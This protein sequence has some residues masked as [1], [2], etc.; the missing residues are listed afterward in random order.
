MTKRQTINETIPNWLI[1]SGIFNALNDFDVP[2]R[3]SDIANELDME[4]HGNI[5]GDKFISPLVSKMK[6]G[7]TL[8]TAEMKTLAGVIYHMYIDNWRREWD[9]LDML[10]NP[11]ENYNMVEKM[12]NDI[13]TDA[14][15]RTHTRTDNTTHIKTGT[16]TDTKNLTDRNT[17][18]VTE[19]TT[20]NLTKTTT[21]NL[22]ETTTPNVTDTS[23][24]SVYAFNS[25]SP[26]PTGTSSTSQTGTNTVTN[27]G[28]TTDTE[29]GSNTVTR[30]GTDTTTHTGS[31]TLTHNTSD[32][33]TGTVTDADSGT[34]THTRNYHLT[35]SGNIGV[36]TSQQMIQ[37]ERDLY[38]WNIFY[39][40]VFPDIDRVMT[41]SVY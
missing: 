15:G 34:D 28:S 41:L 30:S 17:P 31:D 21:P 23:N 20:P 5:S 29:T 14:Y 10:Y 38:M 13:T 32:R 35:R 26:S 1:G 25:S 18:N 22:T 4:Y 19:I 11:I 8:T 37:S 2:W 7:D 33:N 6:S 3:V 24:S 39:R 9:T 12:S 27:T 40:V 36:T 16:E